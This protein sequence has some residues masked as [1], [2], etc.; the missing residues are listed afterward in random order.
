VLALTSKL[1][2]LNPEYYTIWNYRR[3]ILQHL[4]DTSATPAKR[5][6][7]STDGPTDG[8]TD[9]ST[10]AASRHDDILQ[11]IASDLRFLIPLL[12]KFPKCY[13]IWNHRLWLLEQSTT[14]LS[15]SASAQIWQEELG[16]VSK[17][18]ARDSRNFHAWD[19]RRYVVRHLEQLPAITT[20]MTESEFDYTTKMI[21]TNL[22]NFSAWHNRSKLIPRL[23]DERDAN[24]EARRKLLE[25]EFAL[26]WQ[27]LNTDPFDQSLW[28][29]HQFLMSTHSPSN[30][31]NAA[32]VLTLTNQDRLERLE[33]ELDGIKEILEDTDDCKWVYQSLLSYSAMY[34]E[35]EA[36]NKTV[37]T[38]EMRRWLRKL[39]ELDPLRKGRW[40][41]LGKTLNL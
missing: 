34:L 27:A 11:S 38:A 8:P 30:S 24:D 16:L 25:S 5:P 12:L 35:I 37:T 13:W 23:L 40:D 31:R 26:I 2:T 32:I 41:D 6:D 9:G 18:L 21:K 15:P 10:E 3:I 29:Y 20:S 22:S 39:H 4:F 19:Y 17:M 33:S 14:Q 28:F 1:L 36:G 7:A